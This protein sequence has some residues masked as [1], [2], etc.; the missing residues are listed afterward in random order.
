MTADETTRIACAVGQATYRPVERKQFWFIIY[1]LLFA[2]ITA[3]LQAEIIGDAATTIADKFDAESRISWMASSGFL[4]QAC[5]LLIFGK[6]YDLLEPKKIMLVSLSFFAGGSFMSGQASTFPVLVVGQAIAG[7]GRT[8]IVVGSVLILGVITTSRAQRA[9]FV[10]IVSAGYGTMLKVAPLVAGLLLKKDS[11]DNWRWIFWVAIPNQLLLIVLVSIFPQFR[12]RRSSWAEFR[13]FDF[14]G[15]FFQAAG[16][17]LFVVPLLIG[18]SHGSFSW[19]SPPLITLYVL[20]PIMLSIF[21]WWEHRQPEG[22]RFLPLDAIRKNRSIPLLAVIT[23][24]ASLNVSCT[25]FWIPAYLQFVR[26]SSP[27]VSALQLL[28]A[29]MAGSI[30][31]VTVGKCLSLGG[32]RTYQVICIIGSILQVLGAIIFWLFKYNMPYGQFYID[33]IVTG[34]GVGCVFAIGIT[35]VLDLVPDHLFGQI[36]SFMQIASALGAVLG[37]TLQGVIVSTGLETFLIPYGGMSALPALKELGSDKDTDDTILRRAADAFLDT[38]AFALDSKIAYHD[39][40][41]LTSLLLAGFAVLSLLA[42]IALTRHTLY[43]VPNDTY[44]ETSGPQCEQTPAI[45]SPAGLRKSE[46]SLPVSPSPKNEVEERQNR[47][48]T[49]TN[50]EQVIARQGPPKSIC[51]SNRAMSLQIPAPSKLVTSL[52]K[53][54]EPD[55]V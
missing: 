28:P 2:M 10:S 42:S 44:L 48:S 1:T 20:T 23:F 14:I 24:V 50:R 39:T 17:A 8:G 3:G 22:A 53:V 43:V 52:R 40:Q 37:I 30:A 54:S 32:S 7:L 49:S 13:Q 9:F 19:S 26:G 33:S 12:R 21:V 6:L 18:S 51:T 36:S 34:L 35:L 46:K 45:L 29:V 4:V 47:T 15:A 16:L 5:T 55:R 41:R 38:K 27:I 25:T 11:A 31:S